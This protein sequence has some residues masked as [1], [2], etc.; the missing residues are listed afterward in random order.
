MEKLR[1]SI[2][3]LDETVATGALS[4][5]KMG[6]IDFG[7]DSGV[8][9]GA[10]QTSTAVIT[11]M[12]VNA[13]SDIM[14]VIDADDR[15]VEVNEAYC[16]FLRKSRQAMLGG[17][18]VDAIGPEVFEGV[19]KPK[20]DLCR[21]QGEVTYVITR[22]LEYGTTHLLEVHYT[23]FRCPGERD[24]HVL[25]VARDV[26]QAHYLRHY[27]KLNEL[28]S[29][30]VRHCSLTGLLNRPEFEAAVSAAVQQACDGRRRFALAF[31]DLDYFK[32][33]NDA[34]GHDAGD[35]V[36]I[37]VARL[38]ESNTRK[39]DIVGRIGG[40][41][42]GLLLS[43]CSAEQ[44]ER[45]VQDILED[46]R[47]YRFFHEG[48]TFTLGMSVGLATL[49]TGLDSAQAALRAA[50]SA[51]RQAKQK[52]RCRVEFY[53]PDW[54]GADHDDGDFIVELKDAVDGRAVSLWA[55]P[56]VAVN[57]A[58]P[59]AVHYSLRV[60][61]PRGHEL[62]RA[63]FAPAAA[64]YNVLASLDRW[65]VRAALSE[66]GVRAVPAR[67]RPTAFVEIS[68]SSVCDR[69]FPLYLRDEIAESGVDP[70][71]LGILVTEVTIAENAELAIPFICALRDLGVHVVLDAFG[72]GASI[73][74]SAGE[75]A[76]SGVQF[77]ESIVRDAQTTPVRAAVVTGLCKVAR[78]ARWFTIASGVETDAT[79]AFVTGEGV[80]YCE[81]P[82]IGHERRFDTSVDD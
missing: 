5:T 16:R 27:K 50:D 9:T 25:V 26:S 8:V 24:D 48:R 43:D 1:P 58:L 46:I 44:A 71:R 37:D 15:F 51:A 3:L 57:A 36:L 13:T 74:P 61:A 54:L 17:R 4:M 68:A 60:R 2:R 21:S 28:L 35:R 73:L 77:P 72:A 81:G 53:D 79:K 29:Y 45:L 42:F 56:V 59:D 6:P 65:L 14:C 33:I 34:C 12:M 82:L 75:L 64:R 7:G 38:L 32:V 63:E 41:E 66:E 55:R 69:C 23:R 30:H 39:S 31:C 20:L 11:R 10:G 70:T 18:V 52:G 22:T 19:V 78:A 62:T 80:D 47:D 76:V 49:A 40:D 67:A